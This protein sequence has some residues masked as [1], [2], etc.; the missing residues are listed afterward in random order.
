MIRITL[1]GVT[2]PMEVNGALYNDVMPDLGVTLSDE[3]IALVL[4]YARSS[5]GS[6]APAITRDEVA[7]VR[8]S[9]GDRLEPWASGAALAAARATRVLPWFRRPKSGHGWPNFGAA[10]RRLRAGGPGF[11][12][13]PSRPEPRRPP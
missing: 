2:G 5:W 9:L 7:K 12:G 8:A 6:S 10:S 1:L 4:T 13:A 11:L 3:E